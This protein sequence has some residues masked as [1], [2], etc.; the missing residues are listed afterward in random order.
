MYLQDHKC[1]VCRIV[2]SGD[3]DSPQYMMYWSQVKSWDGRL[4]D[5]CNTCMDKLGV[6]YHPPE[7]ER[8]QST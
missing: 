5:T 4:L 8:L 6:G 1:D 2:Y 3:P 7:P